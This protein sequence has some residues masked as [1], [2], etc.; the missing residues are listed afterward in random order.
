[1]INRHLRLRGNT[2]NHIT[3]GSYRV[4]AARESDAAESGCH[5]LVQGYDIAE[6]KCH[7]PVQEYDILK[8]RCHIVVRK[9]DI[10]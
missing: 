7:I 4:S 8:R 5:T 6:Q 2:L 10:L 3:D 1:M 9:Y